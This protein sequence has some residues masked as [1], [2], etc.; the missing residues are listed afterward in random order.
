MFS[1]HGELEFVTGRGGAGFHSAGPTVTTGWGGYFGGDHC[2]APVRG[3][4]PLIPW[5]GPGF[6]PPV[7]TGT[8]LGNGRG[9]GQGHG[10]LKKQ[11]L[12][13]AGQRGRTGNWTGGPRF[14]GP[15]RPCN[16]HCRELSRISQTRGSAVS[17]PLSTRIHS[18]H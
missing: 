11:A 17:L 3:E 13:R 18:S 4:S 15:R 2:P 14:S 5:I 16:E 12:P 6:S 1:S 10:T 9:R 7:V 8:R